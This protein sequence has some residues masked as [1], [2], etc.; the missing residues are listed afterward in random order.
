MA[1]R[2]KSAWLMAFSLVIGGLFY[3]NAVPGLSYELGQLAPP[4]IG[5]VVVYTVVLVLIAVAGHILLAL[6][7]PTDAS[8]SLD[9]REKTIMRRSSDISGYVLGFGVIT[10]LGAYLV[11][12]PGD[13]LFYSVFASLMIAQLVEYLCQIALYRFGAW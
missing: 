12:Y 13:V 5:L 3:Y 2:E 4:L 9:E 6:L 1:F 7:T 8:R 10:S 11:G